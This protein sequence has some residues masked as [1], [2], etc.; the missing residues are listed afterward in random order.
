MLDR[1]TFLQVGAF[2]SAALFLPRASALGL[3]DPTRK[4]VVVQLMGG[5]DGLN[6]LVPYADPLYHR[7]RPNIAIPEKEVLRIDGQ[8]GFH[9]SLV[10]LRK[11]YDEGLV[12]CVNGVGHGLSNLSHFRSQA[13]WDAAS[14][15]AGASPDGWLGRHYASA[16]RGV[17]GLDSPIAL[18]AL[19]RD[20]LPLALKANG[21]SWP[22]IPELAAWKAPEGGLL[23]AAAN[24]DERANTA[25]LRECLRS[26]ARASE[27]LARASSRRTKADYAIR[28]LARALKSVA[29]VI[30]ADLPASCFYVTYDGFDT[31]TRQLHQHAIQLQRVDLAFDAF[32]EDLSA[33][34]RLDDVLLL[35]VSEFGRRAAESGLGA[36]AGTDH[37][38][39]STLLVVG[40]RVRAGLHGQQP[41][42]ADLDADGNVKHTLDFRQVYASVIDEWLGGDSEKVLGGPYTKLDLIRS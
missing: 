28:P 33:L 10:K 36:D 18:L 11:R 9:P 41:D 17:A 34:G 20:T 30:A 12:A 42:L 19:G 13:I 26:A 1:R 15:A 6:T 8:Q 5:N 23:E 3:H 2:G 4:L 25:L 14:E 29:D 35:T 37:G 40:G 7:L 24:A 39:A 27:L 22:A 31:H 32:L 16:M 21:A 38:S